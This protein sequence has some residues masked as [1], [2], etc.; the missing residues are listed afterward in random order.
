MTVIYS[1]DLSGN[2]FFTSDLHFGHHNIIGYSGRPFTDVNHMREVLVVNY[3]SVV[4][5]EDTCIF[6]GDVCMGIRHETLPVLNRL[7]GYKILVPGN[8]DNCHLMYAEKVDK[9]FRDFN[10]Y[11]V[12]FDTIILGPLFV[13][14]PDIDSSFSVCHFPYDVFD[15]DH[16][17][18]DFTE[19]QLEDNGL[20]LLCGHV[21][22]KW[23]LSKSKN[24][25]FIY[26]V[27]VD[28]H[29][30]H[31]VSFEDVISNYAGF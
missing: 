26:N 23:K 9:Y 22:E 19:F 15:H 11:N 16:G 27:G 25:S 4:S 6:V 1:N 28:V 24:G 7:N 31:P 10:L 29:D 12:Y 30:F 8:H 20:P 3:N 21:H 13:K 2:L 18:R 14:H 5:P 17:G